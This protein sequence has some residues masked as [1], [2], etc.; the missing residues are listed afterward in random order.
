MQGACV[1]MCESTKRR[2]QCMVYLIDMYVFVHVL[3]R[4]YRIGEWVDR[5]LAGIGVLERNEEGRIK[6]N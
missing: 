3:E 4:I 1:R 5:S 6:P 2:D